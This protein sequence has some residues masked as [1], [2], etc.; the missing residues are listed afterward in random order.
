MEQPRLFE[1]A[2]DPLSCMHREERHT[3]YCILHGCYTSC[4]RGHFGEPPKC[5]FEEPDNSPQACARRLGWIRG[6]A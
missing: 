5:S 3:D 2:V 1:L 4:G 6:R